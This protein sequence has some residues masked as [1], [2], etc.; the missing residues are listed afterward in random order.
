MGVSNRWHQ[1]SDQ[2]TGHGWDQITDLKTSVRYMDQPH[3]HQSL[4]IDRP[5]NTVS[6]ASRFGDP[7]QL[8]DGRSA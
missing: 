3:L 6:L 1:P 8:G 2:T 7:Q 5:G 4:E